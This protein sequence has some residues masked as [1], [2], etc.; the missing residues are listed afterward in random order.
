M[1]CTPLAT[2]PAG[3][4]AGVGATVA[5]A[6]RPSASSRVTRPLATISSS[7]LVESMVWAKAG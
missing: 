4:G 6:I 1:V 2:P 7:S 3:T 5:W